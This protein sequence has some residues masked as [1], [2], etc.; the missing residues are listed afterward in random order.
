MTFMMVH[1]IANLTAEPFTF[2]LTLEAESHSWKLK[3]ADQAA[4]FKALGV[5]AR[6]TVWTVSSLCSNP[7]VCVR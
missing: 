7:S 1:I 6:G 3:A 5:R 4:G 2:K